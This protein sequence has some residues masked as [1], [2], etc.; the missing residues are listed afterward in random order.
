MSIDFEISLEFLLF[1][2]FLKR[3]IG[4]IYFFQI[5]LLKVF[6]FNGCGYS[7]SEGKTCVESI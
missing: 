7:Y 1:S 6:D 4:W 3:G 2:I 5:N